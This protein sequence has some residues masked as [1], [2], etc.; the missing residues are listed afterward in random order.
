MGTNKIQ[1]KQIGNGSGFDFD[2]VSSSFLVKHK[3]TIVLVDCGFGVLN[4]LK[5]LED[6][7]YLEN[8]DAVCITHMHEDHIGNL[9]SLIYWRYFMLKKHTVIII[10]STAVKLDL[11]E[12]LRPCTSEFKSGQVIGAE[13]YNI[14]I[15][16]YNTDLQI[17]N[18]PI[19]HPGIEGSGFKFYLKEHSNTV[20]ISGDTKATFK[21]E[22]TVRD[23]AKVHCSNLLATIDVYHDF[24]HWDNV[25]QN[26]HACESD[27]ATEYSDEFRSILKYYHTGKEFSQEWQ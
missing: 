24:N 12:Y 20:V 4:K 27:I 7:K 8:L 15:T 2:Q 6:G 9:M 21:L 22:E 23:H 18:T 14:Q 11:D 3:D 1:V 25:S 10:G 19:F 26:V 16:L 17:G 5:T 13:M